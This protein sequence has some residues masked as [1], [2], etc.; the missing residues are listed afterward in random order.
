MQKNNHI[1]HTFM[2]MGLLSMCVFCAREPG[3]RTMQYTSRSAE[4]AEK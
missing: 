3:L 2:L 4:Q 1:R